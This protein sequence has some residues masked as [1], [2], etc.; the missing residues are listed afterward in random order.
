MGKQR[1]WGKYENRN[2]FFFLHINEKCGWKIANG[3]I[4]AGDKILKAG[5]N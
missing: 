3:D 2:A 1:G 5:F 4:Y